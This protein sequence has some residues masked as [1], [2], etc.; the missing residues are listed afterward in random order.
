MSLES[1]NNVINYTDTVSETG[2]KESIIEIEETAELNQELNITIA[3]RF[4]YC[5]CGET[6]TADLNIPWFV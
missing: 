1:H 4:E 3:K 2:L 6:L 5:M